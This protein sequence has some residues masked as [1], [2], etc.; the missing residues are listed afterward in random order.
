MKIIKPSA[1]ITDTIDG[2][3]VIGKIEECARICYQSEPK[4]DAGEL[5]KRLLR[6]HHETPLEHVSVTCFFEID[7][8]ISHE[9]VRHRLCAFSQE[10]TRFVTYSED[11]GYSKSELTFVC[12]SAFDYDIVIERLTSFSAPVRQDDT[13]REKEAARLENTW[14][15]AMIQ[16]SHHYNYLV[17]RGVSP[18]TARSVLPNAVRTRLFMTADLR[19]WRHIFN[20]RAA[21][22]TGAPHP[23]MKAVMMPLLKEFKTKIPIVFD[24]IKSEG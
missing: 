1:R 12:P 2:K 22:T 5:V 21:G 10:S 15:A 23:D 18:Q 16:A 19:E 13:S 24:D 11:G 14:L 17:R 6:S 7:R 3:T 9:L 20:L 8:G 4:G